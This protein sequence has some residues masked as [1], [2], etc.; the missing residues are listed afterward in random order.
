METNSTARNEDMVRS[1][2]NILESSPEEETTWRID[3]RPDFI[4][5]RHFPYDY[6]TTTRIQ[7]TITFSRPTIITYNR[8]DTFIYRR[9]TYTNYLEEPP[10]PRAIN[11]LIENTINI[12]FGEIP[13]DNT[14]RCLDAV[15]VV[16]D[17]F[18]LEEGADECC[19]CIEKRE[20]VQMC[21]LG[22]NHTFCCECVSHIVKTKSLTSCCGLCRKNIEKIT[23]QNEEMKNLFS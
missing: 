23:V 14:K 16:V 1:R 5:G 17:A 11:Q 2:T 4:T 8:E 7:N 10:S 13:I 19:I 9:H 22:C 3:R 15:K 18:E 21:K 12:V 6:L 20:K